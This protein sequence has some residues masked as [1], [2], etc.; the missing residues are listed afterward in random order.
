MQT[1]SREALAAAI[2]F[3]IEK[4]YSVE[5]AGLDVEGELCSAP[6]RSDSVEVSA[7][8]MIT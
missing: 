7:P 2:L 8:A 1:D 6:R 5:K 4:Y 3:R